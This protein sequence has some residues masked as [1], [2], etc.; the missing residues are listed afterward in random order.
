M[1]KEKYDLKEAK[2]ILG[3]A[4]EDAGVP[5]V[6]RARSEVARELLDALV[7]I[8][9]ELIDVLDGLQANSGIHLEQDATSREVQIRIGERGVSVR[10]VSGRIE[11]ASH[12]PSPDADR[13]VVP[14]IFDPA[15]ARLL[16]PSYEEISTLTGERVTKY[17][18]ALV[19][20]ATAIA[21]ALAQRSQG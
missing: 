20:V 8:A 19:T 9:T 17:R 18:D 13:K 21:H 7:S 5:A 14:L 6:V 1:P 4:A 12:P 2:R 3:R 11:I 15:E 10:Q 16:G